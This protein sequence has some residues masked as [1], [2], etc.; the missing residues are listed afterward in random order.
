MLRSLILP[1]SAVL[2]VA[3]A[4]GGCGLSLPGM[5]RSGGGYKPTEVM[6]TQF[7][8]DVSAAAAGQ[9]ATYSTDMNGTKGSIKTTVVGKDG[10]TTWVEQW[11][12]GAVAYGLLLGVAKDNTITKAYAAAKGET[13][14]TEVTVKEPPKADGQPAAEGPKPVIKN[15]EEKKAVKGGEFAAKRTDTTVN[16]QGKD[17]TSTTWFSP[18]APKLYMQTPEGGL[19]AMEASGMVTALEAVGSDGKPTI[20]PPKAQ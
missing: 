9:Y 10:D 19:V 13:A 17:Y 2:A 8:G 14:W 6:K 18:T 12:D 20:E 3:V 1:L 5:G 11:T 15:S 7:T 16:V 4:L